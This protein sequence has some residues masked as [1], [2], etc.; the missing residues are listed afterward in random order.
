MAFDYQRSLIVGDTSRSCPLI[1]LNKLQQQPKLP[2]GV[3]AGCINHA[4]TATTVAAHLTI[5]ADIRH[6][7]TMCFQSFDVGVANMP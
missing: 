7:A 1:K 3:A 6:R 4:A 2:A 5:V